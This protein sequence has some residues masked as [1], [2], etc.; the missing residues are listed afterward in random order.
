[1]DKPLK[2][3]TQ[4]VAHFYEKLSYYKK[5]QLV[6]E[7]A[8]STL[9]IF[10]ESY[11]EVVAETGKNIEDF[12]WI[13]L[14]Y[15][16]HIK[17]Q[18]QSPYDFE[19]YHRMITEPY[20]YHHFGASFLKP[21]V[22]FETSKIFGQ[23]NLEK[24]NQKVSQGENVV[25]FAN[26]QIEADPQAIYVMLEKMGLSQLSEKMIFVAGERVVKDPISIPFSMGCNLLCIY[27]KRYI[28]NPPEMRDEKQSHNNRTMKLMGKI[29]SEGG[30]CIYVAPSGGRDRPNQR[31]T[32][33]PA[34]FDSQSVEMFYLIAKH[35]KKKTHFFPLAL[36]TYT[37]LPPPESIQIELG[38][39]RVTKGGSIKLF[40]GDEIQLDHLSLE[41]IKDKHLR[42]KAKAEYIY[43]LVCEDYSKLV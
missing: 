29:L 40:F 36:S 30:H 12:I 33:Y 31:G 8:L 21:L 23:K 14:D 25:L 9:E 7:K 32:I 22:H 13:F 43:N 17:E 18:I 35:A 28:D 3:E 15:L 27:S 41:K 39:H 26:H 5:N 20:D 1:M 10:F 38:E 42:R 6:P 34:E 24:I 4:R 11:K 2:P 19:P 16:D 37:I